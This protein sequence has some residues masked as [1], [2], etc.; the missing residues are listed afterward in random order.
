[1]DGELCDGP[2]HS[3]MRHGNTFDPPAQLW[4]GGFTEQQALGFAGKQ[5]GDD[6][7]DEADRDGSDT[8]QN[9]CF[10]PLA[11]GGTNKGDGEAHKRGAVLEQNGEGG[12]V[13]ALSDRPE[14]ASVPL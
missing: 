5:S 7:Q 14:P 10:E 1:M 12:R 8:I 4:T 3:G 11:G 9:R 2:V 13:L 6:G